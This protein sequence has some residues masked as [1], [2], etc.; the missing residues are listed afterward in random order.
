MLAP[1][2]VAEIQRLLDLK[3][4]SRRRI[5]AMLGI[6]RGSVASIAAGRRCDVPANACDG[7]A[8]ERS[9]PPARCPGCGGL[10]HMPCLLCSLRRE[11]PGEIQRRAPDFFVPLY[12]DLRPEH[13]QRYEEVRVR[14][15][16]SSRNQQQ[17][18]S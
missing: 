13:R 4:H 2:I 5:A 18:Q 15:R 12:L 6:S 16:T 17:T 3:A 9:G 8:A 10:V 7:V 1:K 11:D 14:R